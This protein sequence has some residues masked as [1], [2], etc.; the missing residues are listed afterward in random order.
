M[1]VFI[2]PFATVKFNMNIINT[3]N[4]PA[5]AMGSITSNVTLEHFSQ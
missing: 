4:M 3:K 1:N 2:F 5:N